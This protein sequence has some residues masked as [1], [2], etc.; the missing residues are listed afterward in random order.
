MSKLWAPADLIAA[1]GGLLRQPFAATGV[2]IDSRTTK[3]GDLFV[4]LIGESGDGH[5]H[6]AAAL[7]RGAA[8]AMV[9]RLP[10]ALGDDARLLQVADTLAG[11]T[12]L[13]AY[14]RAR[15][16]GRVVAVT[17]SVGKTT[18]KEMLRTALL[19]FGRTWAAEASHNNHWGVPLTLAR[20]PPRHDYCV[21]EI[22]M[23]HAGEIAPLTRLARPDV[24]VIT[25][26]AAAHIGHLGSLD[27]IAREKAAIAEGLP[28][29]GTLVLPDEAAMLPALIARRDLTLRRFGTAANATARLLASV[30]DAA[31]NHVTVAVDGA[32]VDFTIAAPPG[33]HMAMNAT[34]TL[35]VI[36][37]LGLPAATAAAALEGFT[38]GSG[39]GARRTIAVAGGGSAI[40][41]DESYN[42]SAISIRAGLRVLALQTASRRLAVLGD[43]RELGEH[44]PGEHTGLAPD[45][46]AHADLLYTCG[47]LMR[48]LHDSAAQRLQRLAGRASDVLA[49]KQNTPGGDAAGAVQQA[50]GGER[51]DA[52]TAAALADDA[53]RLARGNGERYVTH[54][55]HHGRHG[56]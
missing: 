51:G 27:A 12:A 28:P 21:V 29:G 6:V 19:G 22:G 13:G 41:L 55:I 30:S 33:A 5:D 2:S 11:L 50:H 48:L 7:A 1:T 24:A 8:G 4:A 25:T 43:M 47:P 31:R 3:P 37:D 18:A 32:T 46:M 20:L 52:L 9:H 49:A 42:A 36:A 53:E 26:I 35:A 54:G 10:D 45:V 15:F 38:P 23:N 40:L 34:A 14:G 44:G 56:C 17:G 16:G 39:R